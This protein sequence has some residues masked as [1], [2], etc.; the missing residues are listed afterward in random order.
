MMAADKVQPDGQLTGEV[1]IV[2]TALASDVVDEP[3]TL[4]NLVGCR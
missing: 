1:H 2:D 4:K 3:D